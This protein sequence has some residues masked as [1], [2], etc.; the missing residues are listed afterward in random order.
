[1]P[2]KYDF[3]SEEDPNIQQWSPVVIKKEPIITKDKIEITIDQFIHKII[4]K[5]DELKLSQ[6]QLNVK[7]KFPY[8]YTIRDIESKRTL[9]T[10]LE[11]RTIS[12]LLN[13]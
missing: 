8:K 12:S 10:A 7:C 9:P 11:I 13:I 3:E 2:K 4:E 6:I 5:R 1:M